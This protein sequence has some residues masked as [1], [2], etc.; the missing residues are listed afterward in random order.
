MS[1]LSSFKNIE[2]KLDVYRVKNCMRKFCEPL[3][4]YTMKIINFKKK[5][6]N[7]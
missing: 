6:R 4:E 2:N 7:Q 3:R 1:A 5:K